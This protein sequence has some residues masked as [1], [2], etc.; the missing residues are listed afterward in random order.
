MAKDEELKNWEDPIVAEVRAIRDANSHK[1]NY[2]LKAIFQDLIDKQKEHQAL[3]WEYVRLPAKR[4][5]PK[6]SSINV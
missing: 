4:I 5:K 3:G 1:F 6:I 2:D